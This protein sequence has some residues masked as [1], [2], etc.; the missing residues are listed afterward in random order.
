MLVFMLEGDGK[1]AAKTGA[2]LFKTFLDSRE[3]K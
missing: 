3:G 2:R 1:T